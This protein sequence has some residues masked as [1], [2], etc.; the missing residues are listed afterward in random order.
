MKWMKWS[1]YI[2]LLSTQIMSML[3]IIDDDCTDI[4]VPVN[5]AVFGSSISWKTIPK[6]HHHQHHQ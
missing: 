2:N 6:Q 5:V 3:L 1:C 4:V